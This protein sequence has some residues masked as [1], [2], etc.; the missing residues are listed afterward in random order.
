MKKAHFALV[1]TAC[2][3]AAGC[4]KENT[5]ATTSDQKITLQTSIEA[6]TVLES[7]TLDEEGSGNFAPGDIFT[8]QIFAPQ[9]EPTQFAYQVGTT[10]LYWKE[11]A[12]NPTDQSVTFSACYP[13][14]TLTDGKFTFNLSEAA[15]KDLLWAY[16]AGIPV[17]TESPVDLTFKHAM[18]RLVVQFTENSDLATDQVKTDCTAKSTCEVDLMSGT[19]DNSAST[20]STFSATGDKAV[21]LIVPQRPSDVSLQV[22]AGTSTKTFSLAELSSKYDELEGGKQLTVNLTLKDGK[23]TLEGATI[24][25]W[26]DQGTIEGEIIM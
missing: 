14:Q 17:G 15:E 11:I 7:P 22:T 8:L 21:F 16:R 19:L 6:E 2:L 25:G 10:Q 1:G 13:T 24:E 12:L 3:M 9:G 5:P 23:I 26:G 20:K 18:H 4:S